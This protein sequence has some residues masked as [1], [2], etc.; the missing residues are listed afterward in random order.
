MGLLFVFGSNKIVTSSADWVR[1]ASDLPITEKTYKHV[2]SWILG[3]F[4]RLLAFGLVAFA[5]PQAG[6]AL[7]AWLAAKLAA[8]W[9][10]RDAGDDS[11]EAAIIRANTFIALMAGVLSVI[12][13]A[14]GGLIA[15]Y[16]L[17]N[18]GNPE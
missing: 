16:G 9:R 14:V 7:I 3:D 8:N 17:G 5:V 13:G 12:L 2:P 11:D 18:Y 1:K 10:R 4:E 15:G 6:T